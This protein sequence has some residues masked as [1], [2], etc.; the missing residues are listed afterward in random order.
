MLKMLNHNEN[1]NVLSIYNCF[2]TYNSDPIG[3][4]TGCQITEGKRFAV[5][6]L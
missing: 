4:D 1:H 3:S 2:P 5:H 6:V